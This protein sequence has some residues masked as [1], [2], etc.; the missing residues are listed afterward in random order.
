MHEGTPRSW[1]QSMLGGLESTFSLS[2][3]GDMPL[4]GAWS[5]EKPLEQPIG[6]DSLAVPRATLHMQAAPPGLVGRC[7]GVNPCSGIH[8]AGDNQATKALKAPR[9]ESSHGAICRCSLDTP[10]LPF[11][12][13]SILPSIHNPSLLLALVSTCFL[14]GQDPTHVPEP[15]PK[16][17]GREPGSTAVGRQPMGR[18]PVAGTR[19]PSCPAPPGWAGHSHTACSPG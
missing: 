16:T 10:P 14:W 8:G 19:A 4:A 15:G 6:K 5:Q 9:L 18:F 13:P 12:T 2:Q 17:A 7:Y 1:G 3:I 11:H